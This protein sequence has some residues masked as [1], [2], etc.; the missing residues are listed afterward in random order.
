MDNK[1]YISELGL[2]IASIKEEKRSEFIDK[3]NNRA[4]N[5]TV[6][7]GLSVFLSYLAVDRFVLGHTLLGILKLITFGGFGIWA[8]IDLFLV[9]GLARKKNIDI[10]TTIANDLK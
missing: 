2:I 8:I 3:Y 1:S 6:V 5:P 10:A 7:F 9:G 4:H